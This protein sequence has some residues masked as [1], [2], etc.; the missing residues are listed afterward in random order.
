MLG[1]HVIII[2]LNIACELQLQIDGPNSV[3][4]ACVKWFISLAMNKDVVVIVAISLHFKHGL[5]ICDNYKPPLPI[6]ISLQ[7]GANIYDQF[8]TMCKINID[9]P[10]ILPTLIYS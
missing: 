3:S 8:N 1:T 6:E 9:D 5:Y 2:C 4:H 7:V 10:N